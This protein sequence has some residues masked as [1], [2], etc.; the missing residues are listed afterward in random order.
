[1]A[2]Y[3]WNESFQTEEGLSLRQCLEQF[4]T[5]VVKC[6]INGVRLKYKVI[7]LDANRT[8]GYSW[9]LWMKDLRGRNVGVALYEK[10]GQRVMGVV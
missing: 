2:Y 1:M 8:L 4:G 7:L 3:Y 6:S 5:K 9:M 10:E